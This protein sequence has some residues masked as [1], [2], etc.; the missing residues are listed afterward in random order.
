MFHSGLA[1]VIHIGYPVEELAAWTGF[2]TYTLL[3]WT[4][5]I[6]L[7]AL[8]WE[9]G[10]LFVAKRELHRTVRNLAAGGA[11][12]PLQVLMAQ[13]GVTELS[14]GLATPAIAELVSFAIGEDHGALASL[15]GA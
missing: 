6:I 4:L 7:W 12:T 15:A 14:A 9:W 8:A 11:V 5:F 3:Y 13:A 2:L 1:S 10:Y